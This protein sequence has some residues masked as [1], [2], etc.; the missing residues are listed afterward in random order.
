[1]SLFSRLSTLKRAFFA[2]NTIRNSA[3]KLRTEV[4]NNRYYSN[5]RNSAFNSLPKGVGARIPM[6]LACG[7]LISAT[8]MTYYTSFADN[9]TVLSDDVNQTSNPKLKREKTSSMKNG[10]IRRNTVDT[11]LY[12]WGENKNKTVFLFS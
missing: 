10:L 1:M 4:L 11:S 5:A 9:S 12:C 6:L 2:P 8:G 3:N 7:M